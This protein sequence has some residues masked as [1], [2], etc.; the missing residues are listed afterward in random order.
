[1]LEW[2]KKP[3]SKKLDTVQYHACQGFGL[4]ANECANT[5]RKGINTSLSDES[6]EDEEHEDEE[7]HTTLKALLESKKYFQVNPLGVAEDVAT[8]GRNTSQRKSRRKE[9]FLK[10]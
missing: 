2:K 3:V 6:E 1:M 4:Y 7:S 9:I 8:P 5:L 10:K